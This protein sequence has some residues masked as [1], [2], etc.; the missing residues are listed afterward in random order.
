[1]WEHKKRRTSE[2]KG[3]VT[4]DKIAYI[5]E[6]ALEHFIALFVTACTKASLV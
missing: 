3:H 5:I 1:M 4:K 2:M 6:A